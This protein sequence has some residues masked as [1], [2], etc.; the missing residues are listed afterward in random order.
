M[1]GLRDARERIVREHMASED[2]KDFDATL[3]TFSR[4]RYEVVAT[5]EVHD[6]PGAVAAFLEESGVAFPDFRF[7]TPTL[8][9]ADDAVIVEVV[10]RGTHGGA[11]RGLPATGRAVRYA[12]SNVFVF[13]EDRLVCE[14]LYFDLATILR[15]VGIARDPTTTAGRVATFV[16]H[17]IVVGGALL[18]G[19]LRR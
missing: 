6:G 4:P 3:R 7:D 17:P 9:H 8:H 2:R 16:N 18:R 5:G 12:M 15:Q 14:R 11:W 13:E 19:A 10:F 1:P